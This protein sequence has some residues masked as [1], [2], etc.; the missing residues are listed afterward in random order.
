[1]DDSIE[2]LEWIRIPEGEIN[3]SNIISAEI[4]NKEAGK[5]WIKLQ[6][7]SLN[8]T[9]LKIINCPWEGKIEYKENFSIPCLEK[10]NISI[11]KDEFVWFDKF[12]PHFEKNKTKAKVS[13]IQKQ[14][15]YFIQFMST[16]NAKE[17]QWL[18]NET[19]NNQ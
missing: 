12:Q 11:S 14:N 18:K 4:I 1:G 10:D 15:V 5:V 6:V 3:D 13:V 19:S 2:P 8:E 16:K 17:K 7:N 9:S